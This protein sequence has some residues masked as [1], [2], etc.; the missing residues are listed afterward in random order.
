LNGL[1][2]GVYSHA[3]KAIRSPGG[4]TSFPGLPIPAS[5]IGTPLM[6]MGLGHGDLPGEGTHV[7]S[8]SVL[9]MSA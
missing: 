4:D 9:R 6:K 5:M 2:I 1:N 8:R 7:I 3:R